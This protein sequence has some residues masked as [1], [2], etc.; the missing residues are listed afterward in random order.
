MLKENMQSMTDNLIKTLAALVLFTGIF[1]S[2]QAAG[3]LMVTPTRIVFEQRDRSAQITLVNRGDKSSLFRIS[4]LRQNMTENGQ[5]LPVEE[6]ASGM[7]SD[8]LIRYSPRQVSLP[9]G[10]SQVIRL[11]LRKPGDLAKGEYRSHML[12][13]ALP[14]SSSSSVEKI[15]QQKS[16]GITI[17]LIPI[18]GVSI[19]VIVRHGELSSKVELANP[20]IVP[21][22]ETKNYRRIAVDINRQGDGSAYGDIRATYTPEG[23]TAIVIAQANSVAVYSN[24]Q[25]RRF[26]APVS[27]PADFTLDKGTIEIIFLKSGEKAETGTLAQTSLV[28]R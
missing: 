18:V 28:L 27:L 20:A 11:A 22:T 26:E 17:E 2:V 14:E 21:A 12:F 16:E 8:P 1:S 25:T 13:Q 3:N 23:G 4:F 6:G 10:Q 9:P 7:F 5:F 15:T 19:P 24:M